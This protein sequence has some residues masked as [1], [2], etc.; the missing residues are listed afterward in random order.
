LVGYFRHLGS[1]A[2]ATPDAIPAQ[3]LTRT[4][5]A[6]SVAGAAILD[7]DEEGTTRA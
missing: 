5:L 6:T 7:E 1:A 4:A 2:P 3:D